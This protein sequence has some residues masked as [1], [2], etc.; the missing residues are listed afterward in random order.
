MF[1]KW[2]GANTGAMILVGF[3]PKKEPKTSNMLAFLIN[4]EI[5]YRV[6]YVDFNSEPI[7]RFI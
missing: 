6:I 3:N 4:E 1:W 2:N 5:F 7:Y